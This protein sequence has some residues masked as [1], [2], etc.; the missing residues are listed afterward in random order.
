MEGTV[1]IGMER[2]VRSTT[3][4]DLRV[5][6]SV[7][8]IARVPALTSRLHSRAPLLTNPESVSRP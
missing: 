8:V 5:F 1:R 3:R 6:R 7:V 2:R 4:I